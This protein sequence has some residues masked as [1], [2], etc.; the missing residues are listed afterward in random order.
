MVVVVENDEEV[1]GQRRTKEEE[2]DHVILLWYTSSVPG[3]DVPLTW[4][5]LQLASLQDPEEW[6]CLSYGSDRASLAVYYPRVPI[7]TRNSCDRSGDS[8]ADVFL[9]VIYVTINFNLK[10]LSELFRIF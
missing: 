2:E 6:V 7:S 10:T 5:T 9:F 8:A 3:S 1:D 4:H